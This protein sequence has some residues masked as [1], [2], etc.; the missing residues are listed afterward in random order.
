M[1]DLVERLR[2]A[3]KELE[4]VRVAQLLAAGSELAGA[5]TD[6]VG[7]QVVAHRVDGAGGGDVRTLA[8]DVRGRLDPG[9]AGAVVVIGQQEGKVAMVAAVTDEARSRGVSASELVRAL[10]PL[11][12]GKGGG[13]DDLAQGGGTDP[14]R[15]D[16]A[17]ALVPAEVARMAGQG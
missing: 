13:K 4:K 3:E 5:A 17:L 12:G 15:I 16:E 14:S 2:A 6:V 1:H 10:G 11:L 8:I 7:V 9:R